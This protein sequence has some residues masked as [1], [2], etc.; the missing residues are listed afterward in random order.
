[1]R[2]E[3]VNCISFDLLLLNCLYLIYCSSRE[4]TELSCSEHLSLEETMAYSLRKH[5]HPWSKKITTFFEY[6]AT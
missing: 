1:M 2:Y 6:Q 5:Q 3:L 4:G